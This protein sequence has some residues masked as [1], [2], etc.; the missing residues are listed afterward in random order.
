M[1]QSPREQSWKHFDG[2]FR[3]RLTLRNATFLAPIKGTRIS[4]INGAQ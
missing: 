2:F 4:V 1:E 3:R